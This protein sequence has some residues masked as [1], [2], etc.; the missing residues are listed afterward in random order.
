M[1]PVQSESGP[2]K[3]GSSSL[4]PSALP[5]L[6]GEEGTPGTQRGATIG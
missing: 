6:I 3:V 1:T 4:S 5:A 2:S